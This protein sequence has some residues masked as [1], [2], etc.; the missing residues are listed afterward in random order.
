MLAEEPNVS[1]V[2]TST[3]RNPRKGEKDRIDYYFFSASGFE[4]KIKANEFYE[5]AR[6]HGNLYGT[7][8]SEVQDKLAAGMDLLLNIDIQGATSFREQA[9]D[10]GLLKGRLVTIFIMPPSLKELEHRLRERATD[11]EDEIQRRMKVA[12]EEI[13]Q[14]TLYDYCLHSASRREDFENLRAIYR[15]EKMRNR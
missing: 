2:V 5:Y 6:V 7:L 13:K 12:V 9:K 10:D 4:T 1:R 14:C 3:T 8:K 11:P 15:A